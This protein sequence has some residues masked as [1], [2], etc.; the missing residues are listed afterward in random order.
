MKAIYE[1]VKRGSGFW[2]VTDTGVVENADGD[3]GGP[4]DTEKQAKDWVMVQTISVLVI[5][6]VKAGLQ[7][8]TI[9]PKA[10]LWAK[11]N[12]EDNFCLAIRSTVYD[13]MLDVICNRID[14]KDA[15]IIEWW[16]NECGKEFPRIILRTSQELYKLLRKSKIDY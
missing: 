10:K 12:Y 1:I 7:A 16:N 3:I 6:L 15:T 4:F 11:V 5:Q 9:H 14:A 2:V 13:A 8:G